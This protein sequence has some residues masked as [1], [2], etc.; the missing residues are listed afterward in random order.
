[1]VRLTL[2]ESSLQ[3]DR[4][5]QDSVFEGGNQRVWEFAREKRLHDVEKCKDLG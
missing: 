4:L 3:L 2:S 5:R 1:M